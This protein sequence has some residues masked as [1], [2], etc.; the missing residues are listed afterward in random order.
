M[1][2]HIPT[3]VRFLLGAFLLLAISN[4]SLAQD[5]EADTKDLRPVKNMFESIWLIDNQ[6]AVVPYKGTFEWDFQHRFGVMNN[7]YED[8]F[9]LYAPANIRIGFNYVPVEKL[10]VGFGVTRLP[11]TWDVSAK[12]AILQQ[13]RMG[14]SP[15]NLTYYVNAAYDARRGSELL[16]NNNGNRISYFHQLMVARKLTDNFSMQVAGSVTHFNAVRATRDS[17]GEVLKEFNN[18]HIN[19]SVAA[20]YRVGAWVNLIANFDQP[21]TKH[22]QVDPQPNI[23][24]GVEMTSSGHQFQVFLGNYYN[25]LPQQN[26]LFNKNKFGDGDILI[27]FNITRLWNL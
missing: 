1:K 17:G 11:Y 18:D 13:A 6:T 10:M 9:G 21:I 26:T 24:F 12:Y 19:V 3:L 27:G 4:V 14:G 20:R 15:V 5:E 22:D 8:F 23:A 2:N 16:L 25:I 7:G